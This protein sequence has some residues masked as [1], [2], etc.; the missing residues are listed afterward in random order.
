MLPP[1]L[2]VECIKKTESTKMLNPSVSIQ[3]SENN[4]EFTSIDV[5]AFAIMCWEMLERKVPFH[6]MANKEVEEK[7]RSGERPLISQQF[8]DFNKPFQGNRHW[9]VLVKVIE[10]TWKQDPRERP[11]FDEVKS[12][13]R[14]FWLGPK[15]VK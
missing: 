14:P 6:K 5:Y 1:K 9:P 12:K 8:R 7:V 2:S 3:I 13:M 11:S 4:Y 10:A 15:D